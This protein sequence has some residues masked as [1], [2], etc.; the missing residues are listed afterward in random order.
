[1]LNHTRIFLA[2]AAVLMAV[3][4]AMGAIGSHA[5]ASR[6]PADRLAIWHTAVDYHIYHALGLFAV[7]S[8]CQRLPDSRY[9]RYAGY[10][11]AAGVSLFSGSLYAF[12]L[13]GARWLT[14]FAPAGGLALIAGWILL[15]VALLHDR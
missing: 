13:S 11:L 5:L 12:A 3:A 9:A 2:L 7:G 8:V 1:M 14:A 6:L 4:V 10:T 15:A